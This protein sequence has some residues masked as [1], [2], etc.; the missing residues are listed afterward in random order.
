MPDILNQ[1]DRIEYLIILPFSSKVVGFYFVQQGLVA[2]IEQNRGLFPVP[3]CP[4]KRLLHHL[5]FGSH[6][7]FPPDIF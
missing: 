1:T 3:A 2:D 5:F 4:F 6:C 7:K